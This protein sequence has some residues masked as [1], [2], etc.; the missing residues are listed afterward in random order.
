MHRMK[1]E[2]NDIYCITGESVAAASSRL[3]RE[4]SRKKGY[5]VLCVAD[6]VDEY[7]VHQPNEFDGTK[8]KPTTLDTD[9]AL[10]KDSTCEQLFDDTSLSYLGRWMQ[11]GVTPVTGESETLEHER[12]VGRCRS[13]QQRKQWQQP[14]KEEAEE[15]K[16]R[17]EK[18]KGRKGRRRS[19]QEGRKKEEEREA[20]EGG[21]EHVEKDV[22]GWTEV[23]RKK[24]RKTV[25]ISVKVDGS[26]VTPM[27]VSLT[28]DK[29]EDV[30]RQVQR[31]ED[32]YV[33]MQGKVL[34]TSEKL[35]S[36]GVTDGCTIQVTSRMRGGGKHKDKKSKGEKKQVAQLNDGMCAIA[37]EQMRWMT[38]S[39]NMLQSTDEDK[40]RFAE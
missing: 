36:C 10:V 26:K 31:D 34:K 20:E 13:T 21:S 39:V 28:D 27:E 22:T 3:F 5:E 16:G 15:E 29:V 25:Q 19:G 32:A 4:H 33:T 6:P 35:K 23:T 18:E 1:E 30:M 40:R 17:E 11:D 12:A 24:R 38:E 14:R 2:Q 7:V 8:P 37:C 9:T